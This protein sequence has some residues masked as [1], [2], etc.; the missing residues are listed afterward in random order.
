MQT[1]GLAPRPRTAFGA[2]G[3][4][5]DCDPGHEGVLA[6]RVALRALFQLPACTNA[7]DATQHLA[8]RAPHSVTRVVLH[9]LSIPTYMDSLVSRDVPSSTGTAT[10]CTLAPIRTVADGSCVEVGGVRAR[11]EQLVAVE[12]AEQAALDA[13]QEAKERILRASASWSTLQLPPCIQ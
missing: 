11:C 12:A 9:R 6:R 1:E 13:H 7:E 10:T 8:K 5:V 2:H 4:P 3:A